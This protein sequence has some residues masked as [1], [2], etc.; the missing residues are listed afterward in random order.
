VRQASF[1]KKLL[2]RGVVLDPAPNPLLPL[3]HPGPGDRLDQPG[4]VLARSHPPRS[5]S[6]DE[7]VGEVEGGGEANLEIA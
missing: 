5:R 3:G 6:A 2:R 4:D 7:G 1:L